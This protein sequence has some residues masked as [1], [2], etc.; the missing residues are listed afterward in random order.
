VGEQ[1]AH[2]ARVGSVQ[3]RRFVHVQSQVRVLPAIWLWVI[4]HG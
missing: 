3:L 2:T 4:E 1:G